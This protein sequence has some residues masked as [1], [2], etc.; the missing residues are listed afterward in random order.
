MDKAGKALL[1][2]D[3]MGPFGEPSANAARAHRHE[4]EHDESREFL[5]APE[6]EEL[7]R[8]GP[9]ARRVHEL[10]QER[11]HEHERFGV[12]EIADHPIPER[13]SI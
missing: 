4:R 1:P 11:Q 6:D 2:D 7:H 13:G 3:P 12:G 9:A 5:H 10:R 8:N